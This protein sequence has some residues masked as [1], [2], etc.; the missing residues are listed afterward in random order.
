MIEYVENHD[1]VGTN[2]TLNKTDVNVYFFKGLICCLHYQI[3]ACHSAF[4]NM[5]WCPNILKLLYHNIL[6]V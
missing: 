6:H 2:D 3:I 5:H 4:L 1:A